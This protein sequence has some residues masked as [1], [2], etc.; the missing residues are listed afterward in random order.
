MGVD[1]FGI[2]PCSLHRSLGRDRFVSLVKASVYLQALEKDRAHIEAQSGCRLD[3]LRIGI[4]S[5]VGRGRRMTVAKLRRSLSSFPEHGIAECAT[6][7]ISGGRG[8]GCYRYVHYPVDAAF[9]RQL[10]YYFLAMLGDDVGDYIAATDAQG[11]VLTAGRLV[12]ECV[13]RDMGYKTS[14]TIR[15]GPAEAGGLASLDE[16][17]RATLSDGYQLSSAA[18]LHAAFRPI[19]APQTLELYTFFYRDF[20]RWLEAHGVDTTY[21]S[22]LEEVRWAT[23]L[24]LAAARLLEKEEV[25]VLVLA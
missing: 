5:S 9:E 8:L 11:R 6:C 23:D 16:P 22:T 7:P 3:T 10:F 4:N 1:Y 14:W 12:Y 19:D 24:L 25:E 20:Y 17:L 2:R 21:S 13:V 18:V 15:R